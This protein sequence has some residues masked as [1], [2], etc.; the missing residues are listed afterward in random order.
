M[1]CLVP[2]R[3]TAGFDATGDVGNIVLGFQ[4][5]LV[6]EISAATSSPVRPMVL[7]RHLLAR[8]HHGDLLRHGLYDFRVDMGGRVGDSGGRHYEEGDVVNGRIRR[9]R[10]GCGGRNGCDNA[11]QGRRRVVKMCE[12][13]SMLR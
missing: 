8:E 11:G 9:W 13:S 1:I 5:L 6:G 4:T 2:Q 12:E 7:I 10:V 3:D